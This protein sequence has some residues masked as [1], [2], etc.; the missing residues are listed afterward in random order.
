MGLLY[1]YKALSHK[2]VSREA[3]LLIVVFYFT[4]PSK[5]LSAYQNFEG[6]FAS[7]FKA[8]ATQARKRAGNIE[9]WR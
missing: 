1:F 5:T 7:I 3:S 4:T 9:R 6:K 2:I 8:Q